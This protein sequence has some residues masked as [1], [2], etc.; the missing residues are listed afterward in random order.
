MVVAAL[1]RAFD[2][3]NPAAPDSG[4]VR[5]DL[6]ALIGNTI[7]LLMT[8]PLGAVIRALVP[9]LDRSPALARAVHA[10]ERRRRDLLL[11]VLG[12]ATGAGLLRQG[13]TPA[14]AVELLL[15]PV[16][17]R[18]LVSRDPLDRALAAAIVDAVRVTRARRH[19]PGRG[20]LLGVGFL[21]GGVGGG[22]G[23]PPEGVA[24]RTSL[25]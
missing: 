4:D 8:T 17:F 19:G 14:L 15:G 11:A 18:L 16:Y 24:L 5:A 1:A 21:C 12:R 13:L 10:F 20:G 22:G 6:V 9:E 3:A 23:A 7:D 2:A 25:S